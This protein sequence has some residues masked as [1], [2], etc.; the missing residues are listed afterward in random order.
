MDTPPRSP[1]RRVLWIAL[2]LL[3][4]VATVLW[5][6]LH[7]D[8]P[9]GGET[10]PRAAAR[11]TRDA[12]GPARPERP[13]AKAPTASAGAPAGAS[14]GTGPTTS[15]GAPADVDGWPA[16][17]VIVRRHDG[18]P[19]P[20]A[21]VYLHPA[22]TAVSPPLQYVPKSTTDAEG[23]VR[24]PVARPGRYDIGAREPQ[25]F[26]TLVHDVEFPGT[27]PTLVVLPEMARFDLRWE[28]DFPASAGVTFHRAGAARVGPFPAREESTYVAGTD[29]GR[30]FDHVNLPRG[31]AMRV[32]AGGGASADASEVRAP[33]LLV[34]RPT[35]E[36]DRHVDVNVLLR[37]GRTPP[38]RTVGLRF[39]LEATPAERGER[40]MH[41]RTWA[42]A[43]PPTMSI[44]WRVP[45]GPV[46]IRWDVQGAGPG[47]A[48]IDAT[49]DPPGGVHVVDVPIPSWDT[50][51]AG[52]RY[53]VTSALP[54]LRSRAT[55]VAGDVPIPDFTVG[56][57]NEYTLERDTPLVA[58]ADGMDGGALVA[59]PIEPVAG[60]VNELALR[61]GA[62]V[63]VKWT[64]PPALGTA[65]HLTVTRAD[66]APFV[67]H[68][69]TSRLGTSFAVEDTEF[70]VGP[71]PPG[72]VELV[73]GF[74]GRE[75]AR[76]AVRVVAGPPIDVD[77]VVV[78]P[79]R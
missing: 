74:G 78:T 35:P 39:E 10:S 36:R 4:V 12:R 38:E 8:A 9:A 28:G 68:E 16:V 57:E 13:R 2:L 60:A 65:W 70:R 32:N 71:F 58:F 56:E 33:G 19:V 48:V 41:A 55:T 67:L 75:V 64:P 6:A 61:P 26:A 69:V 76:R 11:G 54:T 34:L 43:R 77:P 59:G 79:P 27:A 31:V 44:T 30:R 15:P 45:P 24:F 53:R 37:F 47:S 51:D 49:S 62:Y 46:T 52:V 7:D 63:R 40:R 14:D 3:L 5:F 1:R 22:G 25:G 73:F 21:V 20:G 17:D 42:A 23:R 18:K 29:G 50:A 66:G 72:D